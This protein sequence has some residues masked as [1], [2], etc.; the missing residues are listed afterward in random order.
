MSKQ[1]G[2]NFQILKH[3]E[4]ENYIPQ[5][6]MRSTAKSLWD[7]FQPSRK[8]DAE[9]DEDKIKTDQYE[10]DIGIGKYLDSL[11]DNKPENT[12]FFKAQSDTIK[13]KLKVLPSRNRLYGKER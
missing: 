11:I 3:K 6:I 10:N 12:A 13:D 5:N 9:F 1:L 7:S 4:I 2:A 8:G